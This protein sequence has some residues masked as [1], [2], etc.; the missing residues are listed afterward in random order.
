MKNFYFCVLAVFTMLVTS[1]GLNSKKEMTE[2]EKLE[3]AISN[4]EKSQITEKEIFLGFC[5]GMS[6]NQIDSLFTVLL[7]AKKIYANDN[8]Y[9]YDFHTDNFSLSLQFVPKYYEG[10]LYEMLYPIVD[11]SLAHTSND[12]VFIAGHFFKSERGKAFQKFITKDVLGDEV[13]TCIK[14]NLIVSFYKGAKPMM[15]YS[16]A[17]IAKI[18]YNQKMQEKEKQSRESSLEF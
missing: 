9:Q 8:K 12:Y 3:T 4:A 15:K 13:Y 2:D 10:K 11:N 14:G 17:P 7:D 18:V 5:F 1:C 6:E 16:N